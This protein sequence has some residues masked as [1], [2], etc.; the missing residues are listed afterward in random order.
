MFSKPNR[1]A[2]DQTLYYLCR[3]Y[4]SG[5]YLPKIPWPI[6]DRSQERNFRQNTVAFIKEIIQVFYNYQCYLHS[7]LRSILV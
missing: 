7:Y 1:S 4:D 2:F 6:L 3:T 5:R